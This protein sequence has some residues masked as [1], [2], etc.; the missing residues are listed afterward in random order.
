M[1]ENQLEIEK[2]FDKETHKFKEGIRFALQEDAKM[3]YLI[4][5]YAPCTGGDECVVPKGTKFII[6]GPMRDD[7]F[8]IHRVEERVYD[9]LNLMMV[10]KVR[11]SV[12]EILFRRLGGFSFFITEEQ[13][14]ILPLEFQSGNREILL[15]II[16]Y[17]KHRWELEYQ[18]I[19]RV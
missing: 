14:K 4:H 10:D 13:I 2:F 16:S 3:G 19:G 6:T 8:Y 17:M 18:K 11:E 15:S 12:K 7:A 5:Y 9:E 1:Q